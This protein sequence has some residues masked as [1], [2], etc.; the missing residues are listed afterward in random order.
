MADVRAIDIDGEQWNI[1][2]QDTRDEITTL[3]EEIAKLKIVEKWEYV[4]P[5]YGGRIVAYRQGNVI[6]VIGERIGI[7]NNIPATMGNITFAT[8]PE[9]FRPKNECFFMLRISGSFQT[10]FGGM[11]L[12][13]G[14]I[15]SYTYNA[16]ESGHFS[17][18]YIVN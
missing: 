11:V 15:C 4:I 3:K 7:E 18:S 13:N 17:L 12:T 1:K 6:S 10:N 8:L 14:N 2:D 5:N 9:R 16:I